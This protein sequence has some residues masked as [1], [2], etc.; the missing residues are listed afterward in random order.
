MVE[1]SWE[2]FETV[3]APKINGA[4][5]LHERTAGRVL[6]FF[7]LYSSAASVMGSPGQGN[8]ATANAF[9]DGLAHHRVALGLPALSMNFGPWNEGMAAAETV[10]RAMALQGITPLTADDAHH[11][12]DALFQ[13]GVAQA[14]VLDVDWRRMR[15]RLPVQAPPFWDDDLALGRRSDCGWCR[16]WRSFAAVRKALARSCSGPISRTS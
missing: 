9:L 7:I 14:M 8:Y 6:D 3:L 10:V 16:A 4:W 2:R 1:Q 11:C 15:Q 13:A 5:A 12:I